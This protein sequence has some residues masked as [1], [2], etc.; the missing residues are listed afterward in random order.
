[1]SAQ[2]LTAMTDADLLAYHADT[3]VDE[4]WFVGRYGTPSTPARPWIAE[5]DEAWARLGS[6]ISRIE[7][8]MD[9]RGI[10]MPA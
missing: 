5:T 3:A 2:G 1:M 10:E 9:R 7:R 4:A 8:E 6:R